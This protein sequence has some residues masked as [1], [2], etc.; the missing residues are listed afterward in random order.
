V[1]IG[2]NLSALWIL[3]ANGWMQNPVG[4]QFNPQTM[5]MEVTDFMAVV[6]NPVA[7]AKFVHTVSAGYVTAAIF[8]LGVSAWYVLKGKHV[9]LAKRSM[10]IA[11][12]FGLASAL[13]VVVLGDQ[14][15]HLSRGQQTRKPAAGDASNRTAVGG[16]ALGRCHFANGVADATGR[17]VVLDGQQQAGLA[18]GGQQRRRID[19]LYR[20]EVDD[21][22]VDAVSRDGALPLPLRPR[23]S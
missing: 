4:A 3:I 17:I 1:A 10:T 11:A 12:A 5:R 8:V 22:H 6:T 13:S 15:G 16:N 9:Q 21:A 23:F 14:S 18:P 20:V 2:S 19:G 7:Q